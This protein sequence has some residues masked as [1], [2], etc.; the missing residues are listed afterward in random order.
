VLRNR[1]RQIDIYLL[2]YLLTKILFVI[3]RSLRVILGCSYLPTSSASYQIILL[4]H[5]LNNLPIR[6]L[7]TGARPEVLVSG[8]V[9]A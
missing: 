2:T 8:G 6:L 5:S 4:G 1:A 3:N 7:R 9:V